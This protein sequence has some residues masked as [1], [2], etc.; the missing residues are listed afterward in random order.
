MWMETILHV[1][2]TSTCDCTINPLSTTVTLL[3]VTVAYSPTFF[4]P[5]WA[6]KKGARFP[7]H[8]WINVQDTCIDILEV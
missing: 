1:H 8:G 6:R 3:S 2:Y 5:L 4:L 7:S